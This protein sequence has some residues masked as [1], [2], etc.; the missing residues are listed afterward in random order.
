MEFWET[1]W[2]AVGFVGGVLVLIVTV[3]QLI[4]QSERQNELDERQKKIDEREKY[5]IELNIKQSLFERRLSS[6]K[7]IKSLYL[8]IE[9][10][11]WSTTTLKN[12]KN[13]SFFKYLDLTN[14]FYLENIQEAL[15]G[16]D[17]NNREWLTNSLIQNT[18]LKKISEMELL[19]DEITLLFSGE[20]GEQV[21]RFISQYKENLNKF[22]KDRIRMDSIREVS[23][24]NDE[25]FDEVA[26]RHGLREEQ[27]K[28]H[29]E[30]DLLY[31]MYKDIKENNYI[32]KLYSQIKFTE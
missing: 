28:I 10:E 24:K 29:T 30:Y 8:S 17:L 5:Q 3:Y 14:N 15:G 9:K 11:M 31:K 22:R 20:E 18:F 7:I 25:E 32:D 23:I 19:A 16:M 1:F 2:T 6:W 27:E 21:S 12:S 13:F 26:E 4:K